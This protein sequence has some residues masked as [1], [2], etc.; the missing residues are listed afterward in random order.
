MV[1]KPKSGALDEEE[2]QLLRQIIEE[3]QQEFHLTKEDKQMVIK[4]ISEG[5]VLTEHPKNAVAYKNLVDSD[6]NWEDHD[7]EAVE[8]WLVR[9]LRPRRAK[10]I[11][12]TLNKEHKVYSRPM[13]PTVEIVLKPLIKSIESLEREVAELK[14]RLSRIE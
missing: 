6:P 13:A 5:R 12:N 7:G 14:S 1:K 9:T 11:I 10:E 8:D 3:Y 2:I 4:A